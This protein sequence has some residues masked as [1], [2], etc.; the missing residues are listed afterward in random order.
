MEVGEQ[1][2]RKNRVIRRLDG[3][4]CRCNVIDRT[5]GSDFSTICHEGEW[6]GGSRGPVCNKYAIAVGEW[7]MNGYSLCFVYTCLH[8]LEEF[9]PYQMTHPERYW[10]RMIGVIVQ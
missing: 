4:V 5:D 8:H 6:I 7:Q 3:F 9:V 10:F 2:K 1:I